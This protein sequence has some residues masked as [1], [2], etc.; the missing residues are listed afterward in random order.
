[1]ILALGGEEILGIGSPHAYMRILSQLQVQ[2]LASSMVS[3]DGGLGM[4]VSSCRH[5]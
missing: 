4:G 1:M 5:N 3:A 2:G